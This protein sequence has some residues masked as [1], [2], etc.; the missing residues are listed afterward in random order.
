[1]KILV[2]DKLSAQGIERLRQEAAW[3]VDVKTGLTPAELLEI[4]GDYDAL[5]VRST[6]KVTAAVIQA[7]RNLRVIGRAG[8]GV[9]NINLEAAT[10]KGVVVM[11]T[12]GGNSVSV[13]ELSMG[14]MLAMARSVPQA[15]GSTKEGQWDKKGFTGV[16]LKDKTL[17]V[18]GFGKIGMEVAKRARAFQMNVVVFDPYVSERLAQDL[19][20]KLVSLDTL[21]AQSDVI[22]LHVPLL[23]S[24]RHLVNAASIAKMKDGV[25]IVNTARGELIH[26][27]DL[28]AG[29]DSGKV[30]GAAL[31]VLS[32]EPPAKDTPL[33][34][35]PR[36]IVTPHIAASTAEAQE[37][38]GVEI[39]EQVRGFLKDGIIRNAVN[40]PSVSFEEYK[41][42]GPFLQLGESLGGFGS[43]ICQGRLSEVGIRYYGET[44][45]INTHLIASSILVGILKPI[46]GDAINL[47]NAR[48][49]L[50]ERGI[51][52]I[53]SQSSRVRSF[54]N[55][56]SV[57]LKTDAREEWVE[58]TIL[59][60]GRSRLVS[61]D[62]IDIE[63]P[64][65]G[66]ILFIR[67]NDTPGVIGQIGTLLGNNQVNIANFALGR[68]ESGQAVGVV[69]VDSEV[70]ERLLQEIRSCPSIRFARVVQL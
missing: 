35:H 60:Q 48:K 8:T 9:D 6:T 40:F 57:R 3:Q 70:P 31:D 50:D 43:Q 10:N 18:V 36:T 17:G 2:C 56:I 51:L 39:A 26:E 38:V 4:V 69:N 11:N 28:V 15:S 13:A 62:G 44:V 30:A 68:G 27:A 63:A 59:S 32:M 58:G 42:I 65:H 21:F 66:A 52:L 1:M 34:K 53:E 14:L 29:L 22:T 20:V 67:N 19:S 61:V 12:P 16:E 55:L 37:T 47:I 5:L 64:L 46:L 7:A 49:H 33:L 24:T 54:S 25:R 23:E 41:K 45:D